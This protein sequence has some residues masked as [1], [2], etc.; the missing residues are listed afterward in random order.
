MA[1]Y[2]LSYESELV[3]LPL[4]VL[5]LRLYELRYHLDNLDT[6]L[7]FLSRTPSNYITDTMSHPKKTGAPQR[8]AVLLY[9]L[10]EMP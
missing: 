9:Q 5:L 4:R 2:Q 6:D 10:S 7:S 8:Y 1:E 3:S